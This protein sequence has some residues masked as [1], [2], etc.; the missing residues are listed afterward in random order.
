MKLV[1]NFLKGKEDRN[2]FFSTNGF[3]G[4]I[5]MLNVIKKRLRP[6]KGQVLVFSILPL[7]LVLGILALLVEM[8]NL[9]VHYSQLQNA[10]DI[11]AV[12]VSKKLESTVDI[13][14]LSDEDKEFIIK[15]ANMDNINKNFPITPFV[16]SDS[17]KFYIKLE[18][19]VESFF[20]RVFDKDGSTLHARATVLKTEEKLTPIKKIE[21]E[22]IEPPGSDTDNWIKVE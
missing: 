2:N 3:L 17:N 12:A 16:Y 9:Y 14:N 1:L 11:T 15:I 4:M 20:E 19:K 18:K 21:I 13:E 6:E 22:A 7:P 5:E 10:A 8:G